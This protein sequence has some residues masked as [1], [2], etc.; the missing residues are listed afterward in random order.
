MSK[1]FFKSDSHWTCYRRNY[2]QLTAS[3]DIPQYSETERFSLRI[4]DRQQPQY[5]KEFL[6]QVRA[7]VSGDDKSNSNVRLTQMTPKRDKGPIREPPKMLITPTDFATFERLQFKVATANNGRRKASQQFFCLVFELS[8]VLEDESQH[9]VATCSSMPLIVRGRSPGHYNPDNSKRE[10]TIDNRDSSRNTPPIP[11]PTYV[12]SPPVTMVSE[13]SESNSSISP[14]PLSHLLL[15]GFNS[16]HGRSQSANDPQ[17]MAKQRKLYDPSNKPSYQQSLFHDD[18]MAGIDKA[19]RQWE[20]QAAKYR[21]D[22]ASAFHSYIPEDHHHDS[23]ASTPTPYNNH[24]AGQND[25]NDRSLYPS[26][27]SQQQD[28]SSHINYSS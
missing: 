11:A 25:K 28:W 3:L 1:G 7:C 6:V 24:A 8:A 9:T 26:S 13:P 18:S 2:F 23:G 10:R 12:Y 27:S 17:F 15:S 5:I 22:S 4:P 14:M 20:Q 16:H 19:L 21:E